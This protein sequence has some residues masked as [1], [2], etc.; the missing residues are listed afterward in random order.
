[1]CQPNPRIASSP[2]MAAILLQGRRSVPGPL[3]S[4]RRGSLGSP[5]M[6][7]KRLL[8]GWYRGAPGYGGCQ[9]AYLM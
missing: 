7:R 8:C 9:S 2:V 3:E 1:M 5:G 4:E 6:K